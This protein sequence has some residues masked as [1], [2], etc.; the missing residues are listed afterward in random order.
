LGGFNENFSPAYCEDCDLCIRIRKLG[1]R[2]VYR[3]EALVIHHLSQ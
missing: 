2:I 3:P 1:K